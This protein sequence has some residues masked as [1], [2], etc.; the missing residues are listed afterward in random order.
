LEFGDPKIPTSDTDL[1]QIGIQNLNT[2]PMLKH[3][4]G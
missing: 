1:H 4:Y 3:E 2:D